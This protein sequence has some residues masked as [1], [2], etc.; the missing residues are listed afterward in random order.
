MNE[1]N[2][3]ESTIFQTNKWYEQ[4]REAMVLDQIE[5]PT[6][7]RTAITNK[8]VLAAMREVPRHWF[9]P[10]EY[11]HATYH[12]G[13]LPIGHGQTISQPYI[14]AIMTELLHPQLTH[15]VLEVG[16]GSG[17]Q[18]AVLSQLVQ[19]VYTIEIVQP[20]GE[21]ATQTLSEHGYD[22]VEV[23]VGDGYRGWPEQSPFDGIIVTAAPDHIPQP[24][25]DQLRTGG[26]MVIP[27]GPS[28]GIQELLVLTKQKDGSICE[29]EMMAV[30]F[31]PLTREKD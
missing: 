7:G 21:E 11:A 13:P 3:Q 14:V 16:T 9:I 26:R 1:S 31:V 23:R 5:Q 22:N 17:Y 28:G 4:Q 19:Q 24:L 27:V 18:A 6:D 10:K 30:R 2:A 15:T 20:L 8:K 25:I 12:D 29:T